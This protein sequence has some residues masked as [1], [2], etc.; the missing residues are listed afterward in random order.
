MSVGFFRNRT[1]GDKNEFVTYDEALIVTRGALTIH[2]LEGTK[3]AKGGRRY[4]PDQ[5]HEACL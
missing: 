1:K 4:L 5:G 2:S 3:T